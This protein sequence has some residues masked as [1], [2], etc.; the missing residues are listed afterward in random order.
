MPDRRSARPA[1]RSLLPAT[2]AAGATAFLLLAPSA[3][4][5]APAPTA[6][7]ITAIAAGR[8][9]VDRDVAQNSKAIG[10]AVEAARDR[11]VRRAIANAR[12]EAAR[13]AAAGGLTLGALVTVAEVQPNPFFGG[14]IG[15]AYGGDGTFGPGKFCGT[16]RT[17]VRR[18]DASGRLRTVRT[19]T[20]FGCRIPGEVV[21]NVS[22]TFAV[23]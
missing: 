11:A 8:V 22:A 20:R 14:Q 9:A 7:T 16:I 6:N 19:R 18:R 3:S 23:G 10:A 4:A 21:Q 17:A 5:Q 12:E 1:R 13:M 15:G 2:L